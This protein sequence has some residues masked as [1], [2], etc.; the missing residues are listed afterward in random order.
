MRYIIP[1][2]IALT[3]LAPGARAI[4]E[5]H[6]RR[7]REM[8]NE[9]I[10][11][12]RSRQDADR[13]GWSVSGSDQF[14]PA[15]TGLV[16][17]GMLMH[18]GVTPDD[19]AVARA[20]QY[21]LTQQQPDGGIYN[22]ILPSY[23]TAISVSALSKVDSPEARRA[24]DRALPFLR[25]LQWSEDSLLQGPAADTTG[26]VDPDHPYYGGVGYGRNG[27]PDGSN[28]HFF[29]QAL[30]DA[31]VEH[32]D[33]AITRAV[34]FL[35][36]TQMLDEVNDMPYADGSS[37]GGFIYSTSPNRD[38]IGVGESKAGTIEESL[39]DGTRVSRLRAYGSM[40]YAGFKTYVYADL[41]PDDIRVAAA[42]DWI[43]RNY[44]LEENPGLGDEGLYY[45]FVTF[46]RALDAS[47][48]DTI[49]I[50]GDNGAT[51]TRDWANDL[52]DRLAEL[53][54]DD[55]SFRSVHDRWM[56]G[57]PVLITAYALIALQHALD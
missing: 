36:R 41:P 10:D 21:L 54:N 48:R 17:N 23:N 7:A 22:L 49:E 20:I 44:T 56:E 11:W 2:A 51:A 13:G 30:V 39:D 55:G 32:D 24:I 47:G 37:Q 14:M 18:D 6:A 45:F 42:L 53:Q 31:G 52:I 46:S 35:E 19:P 4:D 8:A 27:R 3:L 28:L 26:R 1:I 50:I 38:T 12:L 25:S 40:T 33:P 15:V 57:D 9:A 34:A 5:E 29:V 43:R 16:V